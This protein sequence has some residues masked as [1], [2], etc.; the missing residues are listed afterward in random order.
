MP[1]S[2]AASLV[3]DIAVLDHL[4][5]WLKLPTPD[6][7]ALFSDAR[8]YRCLHDVYGL[9][10]RSKIICQDGEPTAALPYCVVDDPRGPRMVSLPFCDFVDAAVS[11]AQWDLL[12]AD[13]LTTELPVR[14]ETPAAHPASNDQ[15]LA[16]RVDG[17]HHRIAVDGDPNDLV[18]G[19]ATLTRRMI[20]RAK[21]ENISYYATTDRQDLADFH[22]LHVGVRKYRHELLAQPFEL[23]ESIAENFFD[24]GDGLIIKA[25]HDGQM[26]GGCLL[27]RTEGVFHYK[28]SVSAPDYRR[29]GVSHGAV[30]AAVEHVARSG[31]HFLDLGRSDFADAGLVDFKRRFRPIEVSLARHDQGRLAT[32]DFS[33]TLSEL[34]AAFVRPSVPDDVTAAAGALLYRYF[35]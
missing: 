28:F 29:L 20:R 21:R 32:N 2:S 30:Q 19:Y 11:E 22:R 31:A 25:E 18:A 14:I 27:L 1:S 8:W 24:A 7:C 13:L 16:T 23:F 10:V 9:T 3:D 15:R 17:V 26:V 35:A 12:S 4:D 33:Q 34:T 5:D 6:T